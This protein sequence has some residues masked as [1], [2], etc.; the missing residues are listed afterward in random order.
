VDDDVPAARRGDVGGRGGRVGTAEPLG[1]GQPF[2]VDVDDVD[3]RRAGTLR[4]LQH[5]QAHGAG[6]VDEDGR[7]DLRAEDV[8]P[9]HGAGQ[10]LDERGVLDPYVLG[11]R[12]AVGDRRLR[13]PRGTTG[14]RHP[15]RRPPLAQVVATPAAVVA[16]VAEQ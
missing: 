11:Q 2:G 16:L 14:Y 15:D 3:R 7:G 8:V 5:H 9:A 4:Q 12:Y 6:A 10:R 1:G 13:V